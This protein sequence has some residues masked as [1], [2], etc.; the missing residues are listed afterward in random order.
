MKPHEL[1]ARGL[2]DT[3]AALILSLVDA[4]WEPDAAEQLLTGYVA[5]AKAAS[6]ARRWQ[7]WTP[8]ELAACEQAI[9]EAGGR[10][11]G[12]AVTRP[13][14]ERLGRPH[15]SVTNAIDRLLAARKVASS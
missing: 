1:H 10:M 15:K 7:R 9:D 3:R 14:A 4:G 2:V 12:H 11:P 5:E 13:L 6:P 8:D